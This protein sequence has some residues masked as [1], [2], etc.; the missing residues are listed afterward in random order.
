ML[1]VLVKAAWCGRRLLKHLQPSPKGFR[2]LPL[3]RGNG[4][5]VYLLLPGNSQARNP[6]NVKLTHECKVK[7][8]DFGLATER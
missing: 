7:V 8:L 1:D 5:R 3:Q 4:F 6:A 2:P